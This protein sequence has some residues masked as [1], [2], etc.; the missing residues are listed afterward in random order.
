VHYPGGTCREGLYIAGHTHSV[1]TRAYIGSVEVDAAT[2]TVTIV[3]KQQSYKTEAKGGSLTTSVFVAQGSNLQTCGAPYTF[4]IRK[5]ATPWIKYLPE[6][7]T[8]TPC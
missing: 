4:S 2:R 5:A 1:G 7:F 8:F 6:F 3:V